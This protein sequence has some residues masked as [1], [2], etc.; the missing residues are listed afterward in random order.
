M[1]NDP[2]VSVVTVNSG[3]VASIAVSSNQG[4]AGVT[5]QVALTNTDMYICTATNTWRKVALTTF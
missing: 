3:P 1:A 5:G 4:L 2:Y